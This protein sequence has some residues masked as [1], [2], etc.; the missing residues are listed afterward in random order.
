M[1]EITQAIGTVE[2][3]GFLLED[4]VNI[5]GLGVVLG[6]AVDEDGEITQP[7]YLVTSAWKKD[8]LVI[9]NATEQGN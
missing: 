3:F 1:K 5:P 2:K 6:G 8:D 4:G 7:H 9:V